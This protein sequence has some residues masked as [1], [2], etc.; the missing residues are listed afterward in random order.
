MPS[1]HP[2][3]YTKA[4]AFALLLLSP[5][6][7]SA[8]G[9]TE[10]CADASNTG[11]GRPEAVV[12]ELL[13]WLRE[14]GAYINEKLAVGHVVP[15][16]PTSPRGVFASDDMDAGETVCVIPWDLMIMPSEVIDPN[17]DDDCGTID[18]IYHAMS[19]GGKTPYARYLLAQPKDYLP[20]FWSQV[21][22]STCRHVVGS[23]SS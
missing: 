11:G 20:S 21:S 3:N 18:A 5:L 15:G 14:N 17:K 8:W 4:R 13:V 7:S 6:L 22:E 23:R 19:E 12:S 10:T 2:N 9:S 16:D 1:S